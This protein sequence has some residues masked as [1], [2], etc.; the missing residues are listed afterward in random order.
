MLWNTSTPIPIRM[1]WRFSI[2]AFTV[3]PGYAPV[4]VDP[5]DTNRQSGSVVERCVRLP[6]FSPRKFTAR[7]PGS[8]G[9]SPSSRSRARNLFLYSSGPITNSI[10][11]KLLK[12]ALA[13]TSVPSQPIQ[14]DALAFSRD[15]TR[16]AGTVRD[17]VFLW[18]IGRKGMTKEKILRGQ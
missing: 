17:A 1:R 4:P 18:S 16:L 12:L 7:F 2:T 10:G 11:T 3:Y 6:R 9:S 13:R 8:R 15:G 14:V 5:F